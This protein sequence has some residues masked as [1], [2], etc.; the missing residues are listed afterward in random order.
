MRVVNL[1]AHSVTLLDDKG[2]TKKE[3]RPS[4]YVARVIQTFDT[5]GIIEETDFRYRG[6]EAYKHIKHG[7]RYNRAI[8][9][10]YSKSLIPS[11]NERARS[12]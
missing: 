2:K 8:L 12:P 4:G 3:F 9:C 6:N 1:T 7:W 11:S 5:Y 10:L